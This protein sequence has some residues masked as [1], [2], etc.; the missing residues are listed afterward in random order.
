MADFFDTPLSAFDDYL[1]H[2]GIKGQKWGVRN[3]E[4]YPI[5]AYRKAKGIVVEASNSNT[6]KAVKSG[7]KKAAEETVKITKKAAAKASEINEKN[8]ARKV[9]K[10]QAA[11]VKRQ[12]REVKRQEDF[13]RE[14]KRILNS[15]T[16]AEVLQISD[17]LTN[18]EL[19]YARNR[20]QMLKDMREL[21]SKHTSDLKNKAFRKKWGKLVDT[22]EAIK[23]VSQPMDDVATALQRYKKFTDAFKSLSDRDKNTKTDIDRF[24]DNPRAFS[25]SEAKALFARLS[26]EEGIKKIAN[27][28]ASEAKTN[29]S[30]MRNLFGSEE[31]RAQNRFTKDMTKT[32]KSVKNSGYEAF[33][34]LARVYKI[35][36][37]DAVK[38]AVDD[39][40]LSLRAK[41]IKNPTQKN[42]DDY[43][44]GVLKRSQSML[45][46]N[47]DANNG[48][49]LMEG[50]D[51]AVSKKIG[52]GE[53]NKAKDKVNT[54][55]KRLDEGRDDYD[56]PVKKNGAYPEYVQAKKE[57]SAAKKR[58]EDNL[59]RYSS[60]SY[61]NDAATREAMR[62]AK[63]DGWDALT[64][65]Q[66]ELLNELG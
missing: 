57:L 41:Y 26:T 6:A 24:L 8:K 37:M 21:D 17:M 29:I 63:S 33:D 9:S 44:D 35:S 2:H 30:G 36:E 58:Y 19:S 47:L 60:K 53:Y 46:K 56:I 22:G 23:Y 49:L 62:I 5:E 42:K 4:W 25:D 1:E 27:A 38:N 31:E 11:E 55:R 14:K 32:I 66:K 50:I 40:L 12:E 7:A 39:D 51:G 61:K 15:G 3:A 54:L 45:G 43:T 16:P 52:Y 64:K 18:D 34:R 48:R 10:R 13:E 59:N 20:N 65:R 28:R